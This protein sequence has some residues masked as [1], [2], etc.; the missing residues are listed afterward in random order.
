MKNNALSNNLNIELLKRQ[1]GVSTLIM[2]E[3]EAQRKPRV[4]FN[5]AFTVGRQ[6]NT[7][8]LFLLNQNAGLSGAVTLTYPI[9][10]GDNL[11]RQT[12]NSRIDIETNKIRQKELNYNLEAN[13]NIAY[14]NYLNAIEILRGEEENMRIA[15]QSIE[16]A[17]ERYRLSRSTVLELK[18]IQQGYEAAVTRAVNAKF[19]A[20]TAEIEMMRLSG[21]LI[22]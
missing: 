7:A 22:K 16:I 6:D 19:D 1:G 3:F 9:W 8:G 18:Q 2:K 11:K 13:T 5:P 21:A 10:D 17:M 4:T 12:E 14:Q 20:K 15:K